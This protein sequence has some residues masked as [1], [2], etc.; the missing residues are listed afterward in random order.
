[1]KRRDLVKGGAIGATAATVATLAG[2]GKEDQAEIERLKA[3][4]QSANSKISDLEKSDAEMAAQEVEEGAG[5]VVF[6]RNAIQV[7]DPFR[8]QA[9]LCD[10]VKHGMTV[11]EASRKH[12]LE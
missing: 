5:G 6:G 8:F 11:E 12:E 10:V 1:M 2:C 4:L 9:A 7:P 3:E